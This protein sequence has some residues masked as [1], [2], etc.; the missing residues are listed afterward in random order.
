MVITFIM[1][2]KTPER[3]PTSQ[4]RKRIFLPIISHHLPLK[5]GQAFIY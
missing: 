1:I 3:T 4:L 2:Q 5:F